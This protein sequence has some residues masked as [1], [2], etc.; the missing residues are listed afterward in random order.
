[1]SFRKEGYFNEIVELIVLKQIYNSTLV[2]EQ[3][4]NLLFLIN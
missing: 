1:M 4:F 2:I 3:I